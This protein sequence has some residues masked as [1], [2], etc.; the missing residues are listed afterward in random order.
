MGVWV[1][2]FGQLEQEAANGILAVH[3][4]ETLHFM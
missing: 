1:F 2:S 4:I 3:P